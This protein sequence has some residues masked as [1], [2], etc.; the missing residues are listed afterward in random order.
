MHLFLL[1]FC[2]SSPLNYK[3]HQVRV[4]VCLTSL[5]LLWGKLSAQQ[6]F[7]EWVENTPVSPTLCPA[8]LTFAQVAD[9]L[10]IFRTSKK[11]VEVDST[12]ILECPPVPSKEN[13]WS[14]C[15]YRDCLA[16]DSPGN[17]QIVSDKSSWR[18]WKFWSQSVAG[19]DLVLAKKKS[20]FPLNSSGDCALCFWIRFSQVTLM[21]GGGIFL[22][23]VHEYFGGKLGP[24]RS[25]EDDFWNLPPT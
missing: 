21:P 23:A 19:V 16:W 5:G 12:E 4:H 20:S 1:W 7:I 22:W 10:C 25:C 24:L 11:L 9:W 18:V 14:T 3:S 13:R 2:L 6:Q 17:K 8:T 15:I